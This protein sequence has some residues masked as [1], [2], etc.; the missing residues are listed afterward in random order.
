MVA[1]LCDV[2]ET[3]LDVGEHLLLLLLPLLGENEVH[4]QDLVL[5]VFQQIG[6]L[7]ELAVGVLAQPTTRQEIEADADARSKMFHQFQALKSL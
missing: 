7:G 3:H 4:V 6:L 5:V 1:S 2:L